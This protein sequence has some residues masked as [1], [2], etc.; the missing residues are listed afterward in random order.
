MGVEQLY[1]RVCGSNEGSMSSWSRVRAFKHGVYPERDPRA[2]CTWEVRKGEH[3]VDAVLVRDFDRKVE[4]PFVATWAPSRGVVECRRPGAMPSATNESPPLSPRHHLPLPDGTH[5]VGFNEGEW[6]GGLVHY[7]AH[8][9]VLSVVSKENVVALLQK[10][11]AILAFV[12][13]SHLG[14]D[15]GAILRLT[16][17]AKGWKVGTLDLDEA[18]H[19]ATRT[20]DGEILIVTSRHLLSTTDGT[21]T[22]RLLCA[23][24]YGEHPNSIVVGDDHYVYVGMRGSVARLQGIPYGYAEEWLIPPLRP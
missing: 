1:E 21:S 19:A 14:G 10:G 13:L 24:W 16:R 20:E 15:H 11:G 18:P 9:R 3:G 5:L 8:G 22:K 4:L 12:G 2:V 17:G 6:G 23:E 7:D